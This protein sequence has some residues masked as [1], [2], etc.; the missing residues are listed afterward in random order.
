MQVVQHSDADK[1]RKHQ[2]QGYYIMSLGERKENVQDEIAQWLWLNHQ[3]IWEK[4]KPI[5][6]QKDHLF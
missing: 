1:K 3:A 4:E 5:H 6:G 2:E